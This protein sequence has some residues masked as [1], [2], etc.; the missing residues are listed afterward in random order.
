MKTLKKKK[1]YKR[2][3]LNIHTKMATKLKFALGNLR[4]GRTHAG[5][6]CTWCCLQGEVHQQG[7]GVCFLNQPKERQRW[8]G[9]GEERKLEEGSEKRR[10]R[11]QLQRSAFFIK[12]LMLLLKGSSN[13]SRAAFLKCQQK[14]ISVVQ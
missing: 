9:L 8:S 12:I 7:S 2:I 6:N 3:K 11:K 5:I 14:T 4:K 1:T 10:D 13:I